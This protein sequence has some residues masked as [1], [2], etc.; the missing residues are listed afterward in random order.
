MKLSIITVTYNSEKFLSTC[1]DSIINQKYQNYEHI[2]VDGAS[3]D[4]TMQLIKSK[5]NNQR[6]VISE[7]DNGVYDAMNKGIKKSKGDVIGFLNS[8]DFYPNQN[9]LSKVAEIFSNNPLIDACYSD[10]IYVEQNNISKIV[11]YWKS[12]KFIPGSFQ[13]SWCPPHPTFFVRRS[14]YERYG[15]FDLNFKIASDFDLMMRLMEINKINVV[16]VSE[17]FVNMRIGGTTNKSFK[18]IMKQNLEIL[19]SLKNN[20]MKIN[21]LNFLIKKIIIRFKQYF[22]KPLNE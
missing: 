4:N 5:L 15:C 18:N 11:R 2:I 22:N 3:T 21:L 17:V 10:L 19:R 9:V 1:L 20:G 16:Y 6:F 12:N 14:I 7:P 8:D 13:L